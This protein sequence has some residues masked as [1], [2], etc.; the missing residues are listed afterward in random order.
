MR[1]ALLL[2]LTVPAAAQERRAPECPD[3]TRPRLTG[4][5]FKP[6][7]CPQAGEGVP[8]GEV[9]LSSA[10][11]PSVKDRAKNHLKPFTGRWGGLLA[12]GMGRY[13]VLVE[14]AKK[15]GDYKVRGW[16]KDY[17]F[18]TKHE[19]DAVLDGPFFGGAGRFGLVLESPTLPGARLK[20]EAWLGAPAFDAGGGPYDRELVWR[21]KERPGEVHRLLLGADGKDALRFVHTIVGPQGPKAR[22]AGSLSRTARE[23]L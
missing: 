9:A 22:T 8:A 20:G 5:P 11:L 18:H 1:L 16:V 19:L 17:H 15:G 21:F 7:E 23:A 2:L 13:E 3:K 4:H 12:T 14:L 6:F 10:A